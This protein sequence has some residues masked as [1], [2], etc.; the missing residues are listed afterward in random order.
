[1]FSNNFYFTGKAFDLLNFLQACLHPEPIL[2]EDVRK[3]LFINWT[4]EPLS[5][6]LPTHDKTKSRPTPDKTKLIISCSLS[7]QDASKI[8]SHH[9]NSGP[10]TRQIFDRS[11]LVVCR[12]GQNLKDI[13][14][15][16]RLPIHTSF[17]PL[18]IIHTPY[19]HVISASNPYPHIIS[20]STPYPHSLS[21][22][23]FCQ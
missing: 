19:P 9:L 16:S 14:A 23:H 2:K 21:T 5:K 13:L 22:H 4:D 17:L 1:M 18:L 20:A 3:L 7:N 6:S 15:R 12:L 10:N 8:L 11:P